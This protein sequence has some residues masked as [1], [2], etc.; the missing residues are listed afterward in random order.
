MK[1]TYTDP[2]SKKRIQ[3]FKAVE[4]PSGETGYVETEEW[5]E[6]KTRKYLEDRIGN[7]GLRKDIVALSLNDYVG[8]DK[9]ENLPKIKLYIDKFNSKYSD[10]HLYIWSSKNGTQKTTTASIIGKELLLRGY[11]V[12]FTL[13][14]DLVKTLSQESFEDSQHYLDRCRS[15]DFLIIDDSF[16]KKKVT[17]YKSGYQIPFLDTFLRNRLEID[18]KAT[19]FTSNTNVANIDEETFG[20]NLKNLM[21]RTVHE[22]QFEDSY[23][24]KDEFDVKSFWEE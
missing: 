18:R 9:N 20:K 19:C 23:T 7:T 14:S 10:T 21:I 8:P 2:K 11:S 13:M 17:I 16:D 4:L 6:F 12:F 3:K 1:L 22:F 5:K 24:L 15:S